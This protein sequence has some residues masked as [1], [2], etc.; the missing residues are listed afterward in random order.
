MLIFECFGK[1]IFIILKYC[2]LFSFFKKKNDFFSYFK[3]LENKFSVFIF[4]FYLF[5]NNFFKYYTH[6]SIK[7]N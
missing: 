7:K 6:V 5:K 1:N 4:I 3:F 2:N